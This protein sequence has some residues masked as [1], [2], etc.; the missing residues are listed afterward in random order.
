MSIL[1]LPLLPRWQRV[2]CDDEIIPKFTKVDDDYWVGLP[3]QLIAWS[4]WVATQTEDEIPKFT[5][6]D[7]D[8]WL[9]LAPERLTWTPWT[10]TDDDA[11]A[12]AVAAAVYDEAVSLPGAIPA[13]WSA[14]TYLDD[15]VQATAAGATVYDEAVSLAG[16]LPTWWSAATSSDDEAL[17]WFADDDKGLVPQPYSGA[18][19]S[20]VWTDEEVLSFVVDDDYALAGAPWIAQWRAAVATDHEAVAPTAVAIRDEY[21]QPI[22]AMPRWAAGAVAIDDEALALAAAPIVDDEYAFSLERQRIDGSAWIAQI[23]EDV[24]PTFIL[25][26]EEGR[27]RLDPTSQTWSFW[28]VSDT[29]EFLGNAAPVSFAVVDTHDG[30]RKTQRAWKYRQDELER[31][32]AE[33]AA[34]SLSFQE[35]VRAALYGPPVAEVPVPVAAV[36]PVAVAARAAIAAKPAPLAL[37]DALYLDEDD[38]EE[39]ILLLLGNL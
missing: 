4:S 33:K 3:P 16:A 25:F 34:D 13:W 10:A 15:N 11:R 30:K 20:A 6:V 27:F 28:Q 35:V 5:K 14:Q 1:R 9:V 39:A 18:W 32:R 24:L 19:A 38:D 2:Q 23:D 8:Y 12:F 22:A 37:A 21:W 17:V 31:E 26:D 7:D 29:E 36:K